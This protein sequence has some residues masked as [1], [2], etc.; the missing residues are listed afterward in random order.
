MSVF[1]RVI[2]K[3]VPPVP[4]PRQNPSFARPA[5]LQDSDKIGG[6]SD[7]IPQQWCLFAGE[8]VRGDRV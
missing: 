3:N 1:S 4:F 7:G 5:L 6:L 8:P 2:D